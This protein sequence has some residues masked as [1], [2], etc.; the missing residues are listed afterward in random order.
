MNNYEL[1]QL[2]YE[3][4]VE[5]FGNL[6]PNPKLDDIVLITGGSGSKPVDGRSPIKTRD[7][8]IAARVIEVEHDPKRVKV[9]NVHKYFE[10]GATV[11]FSG[12]EWVDASYFTKTTQERITELKGF[13]KRL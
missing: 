13:F 7:F 4:A 10:D 1:S 5:Q 11:P 2:T 9:C 12:E 8:I 6:Q 3:Q